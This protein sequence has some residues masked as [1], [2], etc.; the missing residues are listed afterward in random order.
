MCVCVFEEPR[1]DSR[2]SPFPSPFPSTSHLRL[3]YTCIRRWTLLGQQPDPAWIDCESRPPVSRQACLA[4]YPASVS[5]SLALRLGLDCS[6]SP[7]SP[8]PHAAY[9]TG[10]TSVSC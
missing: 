2:L 7:G 6:V 4:L 5:K 10:S 3:R 8:S 9:R 1:A